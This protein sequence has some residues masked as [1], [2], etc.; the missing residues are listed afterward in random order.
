M[1]KSPRK[2][3]T[4]RVLTRKPTKTN[5]TVIQLY[6]ANMEQTNDQLRPLG[7][8]QVDTK[9]HVQSS[10]ANISD[11]LNGSFIDTDSN[12]FRFSTGSNYVASTPID[13]INRKQKHS[14]VSIN[15]YDE[16]ETYDN[17]PTEATNSTKDNSTKSSNFCETN[18]SLT[19]LSTMSSTQ[20]G[21]NIN[22]PSKYSTF[23]KSPIYE[24]AKSNSVDSIGS[25]MSSSESSE[26][27]DISKKSDYFLTLIE[28]K[29]APNKTGQNIYD[30]SRSDFV[31]G[32]SQTRTNFLR[33]IDNSKYRY[34]NSGPQRQ[35]RRPVYEDVL[36]DKEVESY[37]VDQ[38][39]GQPQMVHQMVHNPKLG[40]CGYMAGVT[41][42]KVIRNRGFQSQTDR[43]VLV[44]NIKNSSGLIGAGLVRQSHGE[45]YC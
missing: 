11:N 31:Q 13:T 29:K 14:I 27:S 44:R 38:S 28:L 2:P 20:V 10:A 41:P 36:C 43:G 5:H 6:Q 39:F 33:I 18:G 32:T 35:H 45:S 24:P 19:S 4:E 3:S 23:I 42:A 26:T 30:Y 37:F 7:Q 8:S 22:M 9:Q 40:G 12:Y 34:D 25:I 16:K 17:V 15:N 21:L 1:V